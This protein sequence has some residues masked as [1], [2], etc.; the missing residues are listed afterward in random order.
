ME[1]YYYC[2][3]DIMGDVFNAYIGVSLGLLFTMMGS[4]ISTIKASKFVGEGVQSYIPV[5]M[6]GIL[7]LYGLIVSIL[8][9]THLPATPENTN[10]LMSAGLVVGFCNLCSG[11]TMG[12]IC[13]KAEEFNKGVFWVLLSVESWG[14]YGLVVSL[15]ILDKAD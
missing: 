7:A 6:S 10:A 5:I 11:V 1:I 3:G 9:T 14:V 15:V 8:I 12:F 13:D 2:Y 4:S